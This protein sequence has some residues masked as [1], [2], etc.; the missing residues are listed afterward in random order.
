[1]LFTLGLASILV[2]WLLLRTTRQ[3]SDFGYVSER[4]LAER[5]R[6]AEHAP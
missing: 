1:M 5:V 4:W 6:I 2:L 3:A